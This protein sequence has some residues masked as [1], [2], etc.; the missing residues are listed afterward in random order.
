[1]NELHATAT[2]SGVPPR[3]L[4][5]FPNSMQ[6][7]SPNMHRFTIAWLKYPGQ[8]DWY[9]IYMKDHSTRRGLVTG[10]KVSLQRRESNITMHTSGKGGH[11]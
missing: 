1:M 6:A 11:T 4:C 8:I 10:R 9:R 3:G 2:T 7:P 5:Y